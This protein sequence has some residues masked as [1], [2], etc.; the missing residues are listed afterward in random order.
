MSIKYNFETNNSEC[1]KSDEFFKK[2]LLKTEK[3][4]IGMSY[5]SKNNAYLKGHKGAFFIRLNE[6]GRVSD[7]HNT[8]FNSEKV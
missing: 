5:E 1:L 7:Q 2:T 6:V 8:I 4:F 3:A